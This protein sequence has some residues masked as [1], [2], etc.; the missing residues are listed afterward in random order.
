MQPGNA[1]L[2]EHSTTR[3]SVNPNDRSRCPGCIPPELANQDTLAESRRTRLRSHVCAQVGAC[4]DKPHLNLAVDH[5]K[6]KSRPVATG[7]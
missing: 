1:G 7:S 6:I 5:V 3:K 2:S 4:L